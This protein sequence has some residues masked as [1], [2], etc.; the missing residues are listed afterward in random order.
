MS[1]ESSKCP[2]CGRPIDDYIHCGFR[3]TP[4]NADLDAPD[5]EAGDSYEECSLCGACLMDGCHC[6]EIFTGE[7]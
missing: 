1:I 6:E 3:C 4:P 7:D 5:D 2:D